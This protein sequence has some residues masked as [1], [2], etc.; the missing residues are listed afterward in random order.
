MCGLF[1]ETWQVLLGIAFMLSVLFLLLRLGAIGSARRGAGPSF[2]AARL[3]GM[4]A[5]ALIML[6]L[7]VFGL[8]CAG[9]PGETTGIVPN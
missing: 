3:W 4:G 2:I 1:D 6:L 5:V 7:F 9:S 8:Y